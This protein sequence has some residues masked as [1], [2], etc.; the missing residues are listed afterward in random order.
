[1]K[2]LTG[3]SQRAVGE[4][5]SFDRVG[6]LLANINPI[7]FYLAHS[8]CMKIPMHTMTQ[9]QPA[10]LQRLLKQTEDLRLNDYGRQTSEPP[11][12]RRPE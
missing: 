12:S 8:M 6:V 5:K 10:T 3:Q 1:M 2:D 11:Q 9:Y 4:I 7:A